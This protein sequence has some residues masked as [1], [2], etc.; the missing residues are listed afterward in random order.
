MRRN[1]YLGEFH[2]LRRS[3]ETPSTVEAQVPSLQSP[4]RR[5]AKG[6]CGPVRGARSDRVAGTSPECDKREPVTAGAVAATF[7][8]CGE[9]HAG[10]IALVLGAGMVSNG[11]QDDRGKSCIVLQWEVAEGRIHKS[12]AKRCKSSDRPI[13]A[14]TLCESTEEMCRGGDR[15]IGPVAKSEGPAKGSG[16]W[17]SS[18][19]SA[20]KVVRRTR[21][22]G[23][24]G[25]SLPFPKIVGN[26]LGRGQD[27][28]DATGRGKKNEASPERC[29]VKNRQ[30][31][32]KERQ[33]ET[34]E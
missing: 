22:E 8:S 27:R 14:M 11:S 30:G 6:Q 3:E 2:V 24:C 16:S 18:E 25:Y 19:L 26:C 10:R 5:E 1:Y 12:E 33:D 28:R 7:R 23:R 31:S 4:W 15:R 20:G 13:I 17:R 32:S 29:E 34:M 9:A 21:P